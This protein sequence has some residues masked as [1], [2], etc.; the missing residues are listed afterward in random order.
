M[1]SR[2]Y[3]EKKRIKETKHRTG[4]SELDGIKQISMPAW[5]ATERTPDMPHQA[6]GGNAA[7]H[8]IHKT[9]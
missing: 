2:P 1:I 5:N 8:K 6:T 3:A 4:K 9:D 7:S